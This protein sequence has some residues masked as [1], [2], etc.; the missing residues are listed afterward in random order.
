MLPG[1]RPN[2]IL[3]LVFA[4]CFT[5]ILV[6]TVFPT[7]YTSALEHIQ[8][9]PYYS[10][11][12]VLAPPAVSVPPAL[13][14]LMTDLRLPVHTLSKNW[15]SH[16]EIAMH[17]LFGCLEAS[18]CQENQTK[19]VLLGWDAFIN[20]I[21]ESHEGGE[22]RALKKLG[23]TYLHTP[24]NERTL[25]LYHCILSSS[26]PSG[27]PVWKMFN[28]HW[29]TGSVGPLRNN[30]TLN[31]EDTVSAG[32]KGRRAGVFFAPFVPHSERK[33]QAYVLAKEMDY[34]GPELRSW[35]PDYYDAAHN[36]TNVEFVAGVRG[37]NTADFPPRLKN[38]G[39]MSQSEFYDQL[40]RSLVLVGVGFPYTSPTPYDA[41]CFGVP[42]INPI[43][44]WD[45]ADPMNRNKWSDR[46]EANVLVAVQHGMI[47]HLHPP[48]SG[49]TGSWVAREVT[50]SCDIIRKYGA[51]RGVSERSAALAEF[52]MSG[53]LESTK[54]TENHVTCR[55]AAGCR[56]VAPVLRLGSAVCG[57]SVRRHGLNLYMEST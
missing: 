38:L 28:C 47:K 5:L 16:N 45:A 6:S 55:D 22:V 52:T 37:N 12:G 14:P 2:I 21:Q 49:F 29:W 39:Y 7:A 32:G 19:V 34:F 42:F 41:L 51:A 11:D 35:E 20:E 31:P 8:K 36:A 53:K 57:I 15:A 17:A 44:D 46:A 13:G 40:S 48:K 24:N 50:L 27:I 4:A 43:T 26:N 3:L 30:W 54:V 9:R 23:Y 10:P 25:Q 1:S 18:S 33:R 56:D